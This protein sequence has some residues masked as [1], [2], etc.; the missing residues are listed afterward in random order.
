MCNEL[1]E[2]TF[3]IIY[4]CP[5]LKEILTILNIN[6]KYD[7]KIKISFGLD[8]DHLSNFVLFHIRAV[9]FRARFQ[10][11]RSKDACKSA[12]SKRCKN[13]IKMDLQNKLHIA[14]ATGKVNSFLENF[15][16]NN[17]DTHNFRPLLEDCLPLQDG[18]PSV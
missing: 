17:I 3:H 4:A 6:D 15:I 16:P 14:K 7:S 10:I 8:K 5:I 13:N 1:E 11:F 9:I 18:V 2:N 12:L